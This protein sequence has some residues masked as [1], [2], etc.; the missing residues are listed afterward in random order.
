MYVY[1]KCHLFVVCLSVC[2]LA[3]LLAYKFI[4]ANITSA[5]PKATLNI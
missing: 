1:M 4:W 3:Y 5:L 2:L